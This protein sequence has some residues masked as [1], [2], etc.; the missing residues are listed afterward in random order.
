M[1]EVIERSALLR[2]SGRPEEALRLLAPHLAAHP[3]DAEALR[4]AGWAYLATR[5][6]DSAYQAAR[7]AV[8]VE[9]DQPNHHMLMAQ[10]AVKLGRVDLARQAVGTAIT[11]APY[12]SGPY[13]VGVSVDLQAHQITAGTERLARSAVERNPHDSDAHRLLGTTLLELKKYGEARQEFAQTL[14]LDPGDD[15]ARAEM[16]RADLN[17]G[18]SGAAAA[19]LHAALRLDPS[20]RIMAFNLRVA[21]ANAFNR[22][23]LVLWIGVFVAV[24]VQWAGTADQT[25]LTTLMRVAGPVVVLAA[26][27]MW[28]WQ[29]RGAQGGP[30][31]VARA[32]RHDWSLVV[33]VA[34]HCLGLVL[35]LGSA[36]LPAA[37]AE[38]AG[39]AAFVAVA[40][41][42][43]MTWVIRS[44]LRSSRPK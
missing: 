5:D 26:L 30:V 28:A 40:L 39:V 29:L 25:G 20:D 14:A 33:G 4:Q 42:S 13:Q 41:A 31:A 21:A 18:R 38:M 35:L 32:L 11:L 12:A 2:E 34:L 44:R 27:A 7:R 6:L 9:P 36:F 10:V 16:A 17:Q 15:A 23:Q 19:A 1:I 43:V 22:A 3:D 24:R 37:A 8:A